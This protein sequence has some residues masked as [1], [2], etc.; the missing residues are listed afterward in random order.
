MRTYFEFKSLSSLRSLY[1]AY[2]NSVLNFSFVIWNP[3]YNIYIKQL[4]SAQNWFIDYMNRKYFPFIVGDRI[5]IRKKLNILLLKYR[6][7]IIDSKFIFKVV[8][9]LI[10]YNQLH[11][12]QCPKLH[13][14]QKYLL[15]A[16]F[17]TNKY[18]L[19]SPLHR[20]CKTYNSIV[21]LTV[22]DI[23][24]SSLSVVVGNIIK[25]YFSHKWIKRDFFS[26]EYFRM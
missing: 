26:F 2:A 20:C 4:E 12:F 24:C 17:V 16:D 8:N 25:Y 3:Q 15:H 7:Q 9:K 5:I 19:N 23:F 10:R 14:R 21:N 13:I 11:I 1:M 18:Y 6:R 22:T